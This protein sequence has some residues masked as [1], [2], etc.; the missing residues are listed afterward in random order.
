MYRVEIKESAIKNNEKVR[1]YVEKHGREVSFD[2]KE[3][4]RR[5]VD[6]VSENEEQGIQLQKSAPQ[7]R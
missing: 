4:A 1:R 5:L 6:K 7:E 3:E 2:S